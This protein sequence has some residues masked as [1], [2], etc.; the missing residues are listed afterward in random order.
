MHD[1][2]TCVILILCVGSVWR[3]LY[4]DGLLTFQFGQHQNLIFGVHG[5]G[6]DTVIKCDMTFT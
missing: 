4:V 1:L 3:D 6:I 5:S 2:C